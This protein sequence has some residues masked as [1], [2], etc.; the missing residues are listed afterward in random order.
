[1]VVVPVVL[2]GNVTEG[3]PVIVPSQLSVVVGYSE[4]KGL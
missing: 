4:G 3:T 1:M 2:Y